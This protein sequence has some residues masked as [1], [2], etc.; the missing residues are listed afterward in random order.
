M[1]KRLR[2]C[3]LKAK[4]GVQF[5]LGLPVENA[6]FIFAFLFYKSYL[7][8]LNGLAVATTSIYFNFSCN[9]TVVTYCLQP[10]RDSVA[11][12]F[13]LGLPVENAEF[14]FAFLFYKS[15]L[16]ELNGLAVVKN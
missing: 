10:R 3:P 15:Y 1:V 5:P 14:I 13:P 6:E 11:E 9:Q 12:Q 2:R 7:G 16:G 4:S 8:E